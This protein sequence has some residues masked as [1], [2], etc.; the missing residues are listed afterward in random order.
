MHIDL[1]KAP[2]VLHLIQRAGAS[3]YHAYEAEIRPF[4]GNMRLASNWEGGT[5]YFYALV[6]P[7]FQC[8]RTALP[9]PSRPLNS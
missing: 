3:Y 9:T 1:R 2:E 6:A 4:P 5:R 8:Q 7:E